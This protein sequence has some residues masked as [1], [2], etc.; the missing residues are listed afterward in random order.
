MGQALSALFAKR[1]EKS[2]TLRDPD[3]KGSDAGI[4]Y[5]AYIHRHAGALTR[6]RHLGPAGSRTPYAS[7][8]CLVD[9]LPSVRLRKAECFRRT[10]NLVI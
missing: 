4:P 3:M 6:R 2:V 9:R 5:A 10:T 8:L 1:A 7:H